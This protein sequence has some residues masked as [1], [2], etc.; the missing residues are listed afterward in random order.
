MARYRVLRWRDIPAQVK[1]R[2][3][4]GGRANVQL[5]EWFQQEIDR[6]A[7]R[8]GIVGS[9]AYLGQWTWSED[10]EA[11]GTADEVARRVAEELAT[12]WRRDGPA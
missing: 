3:D 1:A 7:M 10:V 8:D 4:A 12:A 6:V 11:E 5:P 2:D 9:D